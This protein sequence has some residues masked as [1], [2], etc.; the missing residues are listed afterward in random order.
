M[1]TKLVITKD[2][3]R[4]ECTVDKRPRPNPRGAWPLPNF[5]DPLG[6][7]L[8]TLVLERIQ[9]TGRMGIRVTATALPGGA[10][11][12]WTLLHHAYQGSAPAEPAWDETLVQAPAFTL[13]LDAPL[14]RA[15]HVFRLRRVEAGQT[16]LY[17]PATIATPEDAQAPLT[18]E[19]ILADD[20]VAAGAE[21]LAFKGDY[22]D[23]LLAEQASLDA[24]ATLWLVNHGPYDTALAAVVASVATWNPAYTV[25]AS[26]TALAAGAGATLLALFR[27]AWSARDALKAA[28][29]TAISAGT[30]DLWS[31]DALTAAEKITVAQMRTDIL[32][33]QGGVNGLDAQAT[34]A[35]IVTEKTAYDNAIAAL[36]TWLNS[37]TSADGWNSSTHVWKTTNTLNL[38]AG[39]GAAGRSR[40]A[41]ITAAR[42]A[43]IAALNVTLTGSDYLTGPAKVL[44]QADRDRYYNGFYTATTGLKARAIAA[45]VSWAAAGSAVD[46]LE[47]WLNALTSADGWNSSTHVWKTMNTLYL[48]AGGGAILRS[49]MAGVVTAWNALE[50]AVDNVLATAANAALAG[51]PAL[52]S[53]LPGTCGAEFITTAAN[54]DFSGAGNW[55]GTGWTVSGGVFAHAAG[56]NAATLGNAYLTA[57][58]ANGEGF[59]ISATIT[60]TSPGTLNIEFGGGSTGPVAMSEGVLDCYICGVSCTGVGSGLTFTPD[61]NWVGSI[62]NVSVKKTSSPGTAYPAGK[63]VYLGAPWTDSSGV[64]G[65]AGKV[66]P[67]TI[68]KS[69]LTGSVYRWI[70]AA[71]MAD[72][73]V[74]KF[75]A[76]QISAGA[77]GTNALAALLVLTNDLRSF[78]YSAGTSSVAPTGYRLAGTTFT[79]TFIGGATD[80]NCQMELGGSANI[81]GRKASTMT[82]RLFMKFNR[83][84]NPEFFGGLS[85]W[86]QNTVARD[87]FLWWSNGSTIIE[88]G[89]DVSSTTGTDSAN[90]TGTF[91][92]LIPADSTP[93]YLTLDTGY[94]SNDAAGSATVS[95]YLYNVAT[96]TETLI[97]GPWSYSG[98]DGIPVT[99]VNRTGTVDI[100][101]LID[102]Q[103][104]TYGIR[105]AASAT[106]AT[107]GAGIT[108]SLRIRKINITF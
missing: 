28:T 46:A 51:A 19:G 16:T 22:Y 89:Y 4:L 101:P 47:T 27:A 92:A 103:V 62:D 68:Y 23:P 45:G 88:W 99:W 69:D 29:Q 91:T 12:V 44:V 85:G 43:L 59:Q 17:D 6:G 94:F 14:P 83:V 11:A 2:G 61:A 25:T 36:E 8:L 79:T 21:K 106:N 108:V 50:G 96:G 81:N 102:Q 105:I 58:P 9:Q 48:G 37:L 42:T 78:N 54:R 5:P 77:I 40:F 74:G 104:G 26:D 38:G 65:P 70:M 31:D 107:A 75:T 84:I 55:T 57:A 33:E 32:A 82:D 60:T 56:A 1:S 39:G 90:L 98:S 30:G 18:L 63:L 72:A 20:L 3:I 100:N 95:V 53:A 35:G 67:S 10:S 34:K 64:V 52:A 76:G 15:M 66:W 49:N 13:L 71:T 7:S 41:N 87:G 97:G 80:A 24:L 73:I 86:A 93:V